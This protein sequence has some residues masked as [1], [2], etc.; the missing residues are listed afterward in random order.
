M[1]SFLNENTSLDSAYPTLHN[2]YP[3]SSLG[4]Q[5]NNQYPGFPP[6]M[7]DG[8]SLIASWQLD[9]VVNNELLQHYG[10]KSNNDYRQQLIHNAG[11]IMKSNF[12]EACNDV[13][14]YRRYNETKEQHTEQNTPAYLYKSLLDKGPNPN[15]NRA[16]DLKEL[17]LSKERLQ[18]LK[19]AP[20]ITQDEL[21]KMRR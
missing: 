8:R 14:Y 17:Y 7:S 18:S 15:Q 16:S 9:S 11:E 12:Y 20:E 1:F 2:N 4:Y 5:S 6:L 21:L 3:K 19:I 13:G 10:I